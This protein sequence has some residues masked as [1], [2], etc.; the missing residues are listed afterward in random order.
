MLKMRNL[1]TALRT[2]PFPTPPVMRILSLYVTM[3]APLKP[4]LMPGISVRMFQ[5]YART[6]VVVVVE[7]EKDIC[8]TKANLSKTVVVVVVK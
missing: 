8:I 2:P 3:A 7:V 5:P 1:W 6:Y 4:Y